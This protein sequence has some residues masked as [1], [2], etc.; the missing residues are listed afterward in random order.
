MAAT[1]AVAAASCQ[2]RASATIDNARFEVIYALPA[3]GRLPTVHPVR[4]G[5]LKE[6]LDRW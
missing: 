2:P 6:L 1:T 4:G 5:I 3:C